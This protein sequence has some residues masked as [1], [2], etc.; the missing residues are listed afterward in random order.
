MLIARQPSVALRFF[1][2][3]PP[4]PRS[5]HPISIAGLLPTPMSA[6]DFIRIMEGRHFSFQLLRFFKKGTMFQPRRSKLI[7]FLIAEGS[8]IAVFF[9]AG[10]MALSLK[11][12]D[13][14]V[15]LSIDII[16][17]AAASAVAILPILF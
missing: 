8:A 14:T 4:R 7:S 11:P 13:P 1:D 6:G 5:S 15:L 9:L 2:G 16:T 10:A 3:S 12:T 17:I